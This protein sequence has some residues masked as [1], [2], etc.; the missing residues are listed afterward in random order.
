[1]RTMSF[2]VTALSIVLLTITPTSIG[3]QTTHWEHA[4]YGGSGLFLTVVVDPS[5]SN[6]VYVGSD[7]A[8]VYKSTDGGDHWR[9]ASN[10]ITSLQIASFAIDPADPNRLWAGT[11]LGLHLS[12]DGGETWTVSNPSIHCFK[13][14]SHGAIAISTDGR[15]LLVASHEVDLDTSGDG[16]LFRSVDGGATWTAVKTFPG[17]TIS[18]VAMDPHDSSRAFLLSTGPDVLQSTDG[19][20]SWHP[21]TS[22]LPSGR[23]WRQLSIGRN[24]VFATAEPAAGADSAGVFKSPKNT[25]AWISIADTLSS[26]EESGGLN[27]GD[28]IRVDPSSADDSKVYVGQDAWPA[29]FFRTTDGGTTWSGTPVESHYE[30]DLVN[31]PYNAWVDIFQGPFDIAVDPQKSDTIFY[32]T[33]FNIWRSDDGGLNFSEKVTGAQN[34]CSTA[35]LPIDGALLATN[36]DGGVYRSTDRGTTWTSAFP[37]EPPATDFWIHAWSIE[38]AAGGDLYFGATTTEGPKVYRSTDNGLTWAVTGPG[39]PN[40]SDP[41]ESIFDVSLAADTNDPA[42]VYAGIA[43]HGGLYRTVDSGGSWQL[44]ESRIDPSGEPVTKCVEVDPTD[45]RRIFVG[46][47][48]NG[49]R[50]SEDQGATWSTAVGLEDSVQK[51][52]ALPDG[53]V[54]AAHADGVYLSTDHGHSFSPVFT[55]PTLG[56]TD[57]EYVES[58]AI[59]PNNPDDI[60]IS[61][62]KTYPVWY[63]RGSVWRS[64]DGGENWLEITGDIPSRRVKDVVFGDD[65]VYAATWCANVFKTSLSAEAPVADFEWTPTN[66]TEGQVVHFSDLS[67]GNPTTWNWNFGDGG[68]SDLSNPTHTYESSGTYQISLAVENDGGSSNSEQ[69]VTVRSS[70]EDGPPITDPGSFVYVIPAAAKVAGTLGTNWLT[71][72]VVVNSETSEVSANFFFLERGRSNDDVTGQPTVLPAFSS[73][74]NAD[75]VASVFGRENTAGAIVIGADRPLDVT[76]RTYN[77]QGEDGTYGQFIVGFPLDDALT[78]ATASR[79]VQLIST[80]DYRTNIGFVNLGGESITVEISLY[81]GD[82]S[83]L[84]SDSYNLRPFEYT[85]IN[86]IIWD[87]SEDA[88]DDVFAVVLSNTADA[89]FFA[90]ASV[91]DNR[92]G[93]PVFIPASR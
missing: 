82:G 62:A 63:N 1:M 3:A 2:F 34:T 25:A 30:S 13:H 5:N 66:P 58:L 84:G 6:T 52:V 27:L 32:T 39:L 71:D 35:V 17:G 29:I 41:T 45:S 64:T 68:S 26:G 15:T 9:S 70:G 44:V 16:T 31:G 79:L 61:S 90:Y 14:V 88:I 59:N 85:Q 33:W 36:M 91:I 81:R 53:R 20:A 49:I 72:L 86:D 80:E 4:G 24:A 56:E 28:P 57:L 78:H 42:T 21:F 40:S 38:R 18:A 75:V 43:F 83:S 37:S 47:F 23:T 8:G 93:D 55:N 12:I 89:R 77:D 19:G 76:S 46:E 48:W 50:Y 54:F 51:I 7:V 73:V 67:T 10:G 74:K 22:G 65:A 92:T 11:P 60:V 87:F 69:S